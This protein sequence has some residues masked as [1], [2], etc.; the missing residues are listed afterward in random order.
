MPGDAFK[1]FNYIP[2]PVVGLSKLLFDDHKG[3]P[4]LFTSTLCVFLYISC[5]CPFTICT[6][7][8]Y[9]SYL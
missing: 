1:N 6:A 7:F 8:Y 2:V 9:Y 5:T 3:F 4:A